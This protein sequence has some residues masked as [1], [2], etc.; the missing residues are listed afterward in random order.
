M[1]MLHRRNETRQS[2]SVAV[3][4]VV[5]GATVKAE[6]KRKAHWNVRFF[7]TERSG[8]DDVS[9]SGPNPTQPNQRVRRPSWNDI[10][11]WRNTPLRISSFIEV[12]IPPLP[13]NASVWASSS[14]M[15]LCL[16]QRWTPK[17]KLICPTRLWNRYG[18]WI[19]HKCCYFCT[20]NHAFLYFS[21]Q[22]SWIYIN[23]ILQF[24]I[25]NSVILECFY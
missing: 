24:K 9:K 3:A 2:D 13:T 17:H 19:I 5:D 11:T 21:S 18:N 14:W 23:I 4:V 1:R 12:T 10:E 7:H 15:G 20:T 16:L 22:N 8:T 6:Q 25:F